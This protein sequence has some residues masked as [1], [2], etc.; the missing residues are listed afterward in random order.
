MQLQIVKC[1]DYL[2]VY[3]FK[4]QKIY[5]VIFDYIPIVRIPNAIQENTV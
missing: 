2:V 4:I 1:V 5:Y 3:P